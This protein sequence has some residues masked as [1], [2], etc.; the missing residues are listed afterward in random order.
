MVG[1]STCGGGGGGA[2]GLTSGFFKAECSAR[3]VFGLEKARR[4]PTA[5]RTSS[6]SL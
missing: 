1:R 2:S 3:I 4:S 5:L 6:S